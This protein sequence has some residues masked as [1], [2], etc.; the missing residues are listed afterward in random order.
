MERDTRLRAAV[1]LV[2][3]VRLYTLTP[4]EDAMVRQVVDMA[5][6]GCRARR[7]REGDRLAL[8]LTIRTSLYVMVP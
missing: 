2:R 6:Y 1:R 7:I 5:F 3:Q 4:R 8:Y